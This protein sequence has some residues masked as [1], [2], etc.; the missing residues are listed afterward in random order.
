MIVDQKPD[1]AVVVGSA[2]ICLSH[3]SFLPFRA[4]T[5][6]AYPSLEIFEDSYNC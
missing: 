5:I 3:Y 2:G 1:F 4:A 6:K